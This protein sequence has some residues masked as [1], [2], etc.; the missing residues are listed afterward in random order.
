MSQDT[1]TSNKADS[2]A[3]DGKVKL[4]AIIAATT[5]LIGAS[6]G[7][8]AVA[9]S[10]VYQHAKLYVTEGGF[11]NSASTTH[12]N[13]FVQQAGWGGDKHRSWGRGKHRG[14]GGKHFSEMSD[15]DIEKRV[16][17]VVKHVSIEIEATPEQEQKITT[18]V[19]ALAKDMR[20][21]REDFRA[22]GKEMH[23]LLIADTINRE[24]IEK[25]R[26]ERLAE[27]DRI[28]K[29]V[30]TAIA[31]VAEVLTLEQRKILQERIEQFRGMRRHWRR[32]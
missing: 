22:A 2:A 8:Q 7:V 15:A 29:E 12:E 28:S 27:A 3:R 13:P 10:K 31:D 14:W 5:M 16:T 20:P 18:L 9:D 26:T 24:A 11:S 6:F 23:K 21:L 19:T 1:N 30:T 4:T 17:R 32:G 25:I